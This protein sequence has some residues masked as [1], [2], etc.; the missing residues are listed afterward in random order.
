[1]ILRKL[2]S[3]LSRLRSDERGSI[4]VEAVLVFPLL[5]WCYLASFVFFDAFKAQSTNDKA[6]FAVADILSRETAMIND[7]YLASLRDV[8]A[9]MTFSRKPNRLRFSVI[10]WDEDD[11]RHHVIWSEIV[12]AAGKTPLEEVDVEPES[13]VAAKM[14]AMSDGEKLIVVETWLAYEPA[15]NI[16]LDAFVFDGFTVIR[17]RYAPQLCFDNDN[18]GDINTALC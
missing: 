5:T 11:N 7:D 9:L 15:F 12:G 3:R 4:A 2:L 16:G 18:S 13:A 1:M 6:A 17:P 10:E 14:P 8:H